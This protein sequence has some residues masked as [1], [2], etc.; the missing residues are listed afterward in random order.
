[1]KDSTRRF[2]EK[3]DNFNVTRAVD[4]RTFLAGAG[5]AILAGSATALSARSY[6]RVPGANDRIRL[7]QLGCGG[8]SQGHVRMVH[9]AAQR[10][11]V[12]VIAVCD[13]WRLARE[14]RS[15]QVKDLFGTTPQAYKYSEEMLAN[16]D[17]DGVM[18]ATGDHQHAKLCIEVV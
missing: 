8:R 12:E 7:G 4:R 9:M 3:A 2:D 11:P 18:I 14:R 17:I 10:T 5:S 6:A 13:I 16:R 1:M 15:A